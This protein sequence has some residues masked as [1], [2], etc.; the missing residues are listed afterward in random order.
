MEHPTR[1]LL[2]MGTGWILVGTALVMVPPRAHTDT[3]PGQALR[4]LQQMQASTR[5]A[6]VK[7]DKVAACQT[8]AQA[9][10]I[11]LGTLNARVRAVQATND[12]AQ[13][14]ATLAEVQRQ[15][16]AI[17]EQLALCMD[18]QESPR[19]GHSRRI[20]LLL[21]GGQHAGAMPGAHTMLPRHGSPSRVLETRQ[22]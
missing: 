18:T 22:W 7:A 15:Q 9:I 2:T 6:P 16:S 3:P 14:R 1:Q 4:I 10:S 17:Q 8:Q 20:A 19:H 11:T 12:P 21:V 13:M 5:K